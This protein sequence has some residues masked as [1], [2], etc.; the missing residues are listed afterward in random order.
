MEKKRTEDTRKDW[1]KNTF[2]NSGQMEK[3]VF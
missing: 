2:C 3:T 1:S